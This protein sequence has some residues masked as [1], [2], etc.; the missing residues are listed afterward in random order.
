MLPF[1][2]FLRQH[3]FY[4]KDN[5]DNLNNFFSV[6]REIFAHPFCFKDNLDNLGQ[7]R[8]TFNFLSIRVSVD[9]VAS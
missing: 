4:F 2:C 6:N 5:L 1:F 3:F 7:L 8:T 9:A